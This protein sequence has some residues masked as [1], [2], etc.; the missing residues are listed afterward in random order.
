MLCPR[1]FLKT[2]K[3]NKP[4]ITPKFWSLAKHEMLL[5]LCTLVLTASIVM[6]A[7]G[8][9][10]A[11][12]QYF[13]VKLMMISAGKGDQCS[14]PTVEKSVQAMKTYFHIQADVE[15]QN[16]HDET[17]A[18]CIIKSFISIHNRLLLAAF[19]ERISS[20]V[21]RKL[22]VLN[23]VLVP[24]HQTKVT[25]LLQREPQRRKRDTFIAPNM[26]DIYDFDEMACAF[27]AKYPTQK[28]VFQTGSDHG[29]QAT[30]ALLMG[31]HMM[32]RHGLGFEE[33]YLAFR[34]LHSII[35]PQPLN[36]LRISVKSCL[37]AFCRAK[38]SEWITFKDPVEGSPDK[39]GSINIDEYL[40]YARCRLL[41]RRSLPSLLFL[42]SR[43]S[44][45]TQLRKPCHT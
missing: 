42:L 35:D 45:S 40:H 16:L 41:L 13:L 26:E 21:F 17:K 29:S 20:A 33:T 39:P 2:V 27:E 14:G 28:I 30:I 43:T 12:R 36:E 38:C 3:C 5:E 11:F 8:Y 4:R 9:I 25:E 7:Q 10:L 37:R 6:L 34:R 23:Y 19:D 22:S 15:E 24:L 1:G 18:Q 44:A 32:L 31:C